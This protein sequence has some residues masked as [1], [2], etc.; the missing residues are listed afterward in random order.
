MKKFLFAMLML[1]TMGMSGFAQT[2]TVAN[3][4]ETNA[5]VPI[6]GYYADA[7]LISQTIYPAS[8]L[9][10]M[11]G[12]DIISMLFY[13]SSS[14]ASNWGVNFEVRLKEV[15]DSIF[16]SESFITTAATD[17][18]YT[19]PMNPVSD[20]I[21]INLDVP[22]SYNG[23]NLLLEVRSLN[24][25]SYSQAYFYG[26][27]ATSASVQGYDYSD[28]NDIEPDYQDFIPKTT[29]G[30]GVAPTC[31]KVSNLSVTNITGATANLSWSPNVLGT[32]SSYNIYVLDNSTGNVNMETTTATSYVLT[33]LSESTSYTV[34]VFVSCTDGTDGDTVFKHFT[35]TCLS[36]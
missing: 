6:Y 9:T 35:T 29:F 16:S 28:V 7:Y 31:G 18:V 3:G 19:G 5:Y 10:T 24:T 14:P 30:Y 26:I 8:M 20:Q 25:G 17:V 36:P 34:G 27:T 2:L 23:G 21:E 33:G 32:A 4:T 12:E 11:N 13:L 22:Y 1:M 15:P